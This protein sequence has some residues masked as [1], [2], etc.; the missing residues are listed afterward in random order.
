MPSPKQKTGRT[1]WEVTA[2]V[3]CGLPALTVALVAL[4]LWARHDDLLC[5]VS[6]PSYCSP[7]ITDD[8]G[9]SLIRLE[10]SGQSINFALN[11]SLPPAEGRVTRLTLVSSPDSLDLCGGTAAATCQDL[12]GTACVQLGL[13]SPC[14]FI[15][16]RVETDIGELVE[17]NSLAYQLQLATE[18]HPSL[19]QCAVWQGTCLRS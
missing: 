6:Q 16:G 1:L 18:G 14:E 11:Y 3:L 8:T 13:T 9:R 17:R 7:L 5:A 2:L 4:S 19:A 15:R 12:E 10:L